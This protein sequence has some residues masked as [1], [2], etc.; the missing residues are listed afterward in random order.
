ME[1]TP[2]VVTMLTFIGWA[3]TLR[4]GGAMQRYHA[5]PTPRR[6]HIAI[7]NT[8]VSLIPLTLAIWLA[9]PR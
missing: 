2:L 5:E 4:A 6:K 8:I 9:W 3:W 1:I 7:G